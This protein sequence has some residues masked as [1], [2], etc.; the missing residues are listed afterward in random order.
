MQVLASRKQSVFW[1]CVAI[2]IIVCFESKIGRI[3]KCANQCWANKL[4]SFN[5]IRR[6]TKASTYVYER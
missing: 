5:R 1:K 4:K 3:P 2:F 6:N